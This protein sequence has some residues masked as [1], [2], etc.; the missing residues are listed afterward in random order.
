[1]P[2][3]TMFQVGTNP[4]HFHYFSRSSLRAYIAKAGLK[5]EL[6][7]TDPDVDNLFHRI[8]A[9]S[10]VP[11]GRIISRALRAFP[12]DTAVACVNLQQE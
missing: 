1:M 11:G 8:P 6:E 12:G 2:F 3:E 9:F 5:A 10:W 4:P 7:W